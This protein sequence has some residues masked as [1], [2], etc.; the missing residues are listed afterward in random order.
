MLSF[1]LQVCT[2]ALHSTKKVLEF[3]RV[4]LQHIPRLD[5][6]QK[7]DSNDCLFYFMGGWQGWGL[8]RRALLFWVCIAYRPTI[9]SHDELKDLCRDSGCISE[10]S[11]YMA[12]RSLKL[13]GAGAVRGSEGPPADDDDLA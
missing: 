5:D 12:V 7:Y 2:K 4:G 6:I 8:W 13:L 3:R 1:M 11:V 10:R 9:I